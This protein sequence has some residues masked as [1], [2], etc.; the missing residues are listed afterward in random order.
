L[1]AIYGLQ[2]EQRPAKT[3]HDLQRRRPKPPPGHHNRTTTLF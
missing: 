2:R 3:A 1:K